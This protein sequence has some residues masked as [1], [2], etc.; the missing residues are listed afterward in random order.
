MGLSNISKK[1]HEDKLNEHERLSNF[2]LPQ[3]LK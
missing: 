1:G 3:K 2:T